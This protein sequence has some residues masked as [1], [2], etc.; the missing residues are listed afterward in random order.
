MAEH[1]FERFRRLRGLPAPA[2]APQSGVHEPVPPHVSH[3]GGGDAATLQQPSTAASGAERRTEK[4]AGDPHQAIHAGD[5]CYLLSGDGVQQNREPYFI[6]S[7]EIGSDR[8]LYARF[9]E[10]DG[11]WPLAQCERTDPPAP[12]GPPDDVEKF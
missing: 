7:V 10:M 5:Y 11:G 9:Y 1:A 2:H 6:S 8:Q 3:G 12:V 4:R